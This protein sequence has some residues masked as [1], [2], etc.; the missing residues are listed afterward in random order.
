MSRA[1]SNALKA[2]VAGQ[3]TGEVFLFLLEIDHD[4]LVTP[5]RVCNNM[6]DITSNGELFVAYP[7]ELALPSDSND[8]SPKTRLSIDNIDRSL[9]ATIRSITSAPTVRIMAVLASTPDTLEVDL[10]GF[11]LVNISADAMAISGDLS[12]EDFTTEPF[13]GDRFLPSST[14][15]LF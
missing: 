3:E 6:E 14:P 4:N 7:F 2:A 9:M 13:P 12:I 1:T 15:G 5:I 10:P 8:E 11:S